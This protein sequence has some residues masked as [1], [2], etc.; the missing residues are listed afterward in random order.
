MVITERM[1]I[2]SDISPTVEILVSDR[3][4]ATPDN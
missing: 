3:S 1:I 4:R 2:L